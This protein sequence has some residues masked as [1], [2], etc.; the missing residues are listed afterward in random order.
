[1]MHA[2]TFV[3]RR[4]LEHRRLENF[5]NRSLAFNDEAN[6]VPSTAAWAR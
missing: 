4:G 6:L 2:K 5:D 3:D 1:M